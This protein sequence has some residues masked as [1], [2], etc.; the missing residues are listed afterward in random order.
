MTSHVL[1]APEKMTITTLSGHGVTL[2][3][4]ETREVNPEIFAAGIQKG[5]YPVM[6]GV[7]LDP[8]APA[9]ATPDVSGSAPQLDFGSP[10]L[11][12]STV[13][14]DDD[15]GEEDRYPAGATVDP[16][17]PIDPTDENVI[18]ALKAIAKRADAK[19]FNPTGIPKATA[20]VRQMN[21]TPVDAETR[22][23]LWAV[24]AREIGT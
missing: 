10:G 19:E 4:G 12:G 21:G 8:T 5:A 24:V 1:Y 23:R 16:A 22:E 13:V 3:K 2:Q 20:L 15:D 11:E 18:L 6:A 17:A 14:G 7:T 9:P